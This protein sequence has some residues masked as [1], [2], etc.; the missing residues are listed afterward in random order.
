MGT[1]RGEMAVE[2]N[3]NSSPTWRISEGVP[4]TDLRDRSCEADLVQFRRYDTLKMET[5]AIDVT[6]RTTMSRNFVNGD[7]S[8]HVSF[9]PIIIMAQCFSVLPVSGINSPDPSNLK[10]TWRSPRI[11]YCGI[12]FLSA[13][14]MTIFCV[15][16]LARTDITSTKTTSAVFFG[17]SCMTT[18][19]FLQLATRWP[20]FVLAWNKFERERTSPR[21]VSRISLA[22]RFRILTVVIMG[23]AF[24]EHTLSILSGYSSAVEC[25]AVRGDSDILSVYF[26]SQFPQVFTRTPYAHW[27]GA[28]V[29]MLNI[30]STFSWNF[31]DLFLILI[32]VALTDQFRQLN[33][34]LDL[35]K[36]KIM[37]DRW[38]S[39]ARTD[40][41]RLAILSRLVDSN[42]SEIVLLSF[43]NNLYFICI[44]LLNSVN[45]KPM[46]D[47]IHTIYFCFSFGFL[48]ARTAA[49][50]LFAAAVHDES[51]LPAPVLYG[52]SSSSYSS[53]VLRFLLQ[54]TTDNIALS[55]MK[56]FSITRSLVL[57]VA[58]TIVT[59][60]LVLV[61]FNAVQQS[62]SLQI[63]ITTACMIRT[64]LFA[65]KLLAF[66]ILIHA[67]PTEISLP[68]VDLPFD[69]TISFTT[70]PF[71][72]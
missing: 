21:N 40:Y 8:L 45:Y 60:E 65:R 22:L 62:D 31:M 38:W 53:E 61:Q 33:R 66:H 51:L 42:V 34:R 32:S 26:E 19:L 49:M 28:V 10:F 30:L 46:R 29:L 72:L 52:V 13:S 20:S 55:G 37:S 15:I 71:S 11:L 44:Q 64:S 35:T 12:S 1:Y 59:Y 7:N 39:E 5:A 70:S 24:V 17:T 6:P 9:R 4:L 25:V 63:N 16:H 69:S 18:L 47:A 56:F 41:N 58:G 48:L 50:S 57:T 54:V 27:K 2:G 36:E 68:C 14:L 23:L 67:G 43:A 3:E